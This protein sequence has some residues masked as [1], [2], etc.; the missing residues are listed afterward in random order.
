M[1]NVDAAIGHY[2]IADQP[3]SEQEWIEQRTVMEQKRGPKQIDSQVLV[4]DEQKPQD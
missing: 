1:Q 2:I 3:L 4:E